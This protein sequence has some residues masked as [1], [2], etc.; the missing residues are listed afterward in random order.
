MAHR[1]LLVEDD[2]AILRGLEMNL[3]VEGYEV[4]AVAD[5]REALT[6]LQGPP[7]D[8]AVFDLMLPGLNGY[9]LVQEVRRKKLDMPIIL[10]SAKSSEYDKIL[11][12]DTGADDYVTKPFSVGE[13]LARIKAHLRRRGPGSVVRFGGVEVDL[14]RRTVK[15]DGEAVSLSTREFDLLALLIKREGRPVTRDSILT[16][17]WGSHYF[18]TDRTVDN[19]INRLRSKI[20]TNAEPKHL[21]TVRGVGYRLALDPE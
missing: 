6:A 13:L 14:D 7:F 10:L 16:L 12:L 20:D 5:G 15:R 2:R 17:V 18:G 11:G 9:Q 19:F 3:Q 4:V 21:L 8:L 1:I